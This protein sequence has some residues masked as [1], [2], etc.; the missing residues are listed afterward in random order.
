MVWFDYREK[1]FSFQGW[2]IWKVLEDES[3]GARIELE[4]S[5]VEPREPLRLTT[6]LSVNQG[7]DALVRYLGVADVQVLYF[8]TVFAD[9]RSNLRE[10]PVSDRV[11]LFVL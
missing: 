9:C 8:R 3:N 11:C 7:Q 2:E 1:V 5:D 6:A 4:A 10:I